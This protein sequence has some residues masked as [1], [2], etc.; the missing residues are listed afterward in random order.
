MDSKRSPI[1]A[2]RGL[3]MKVEDQE[4]VEVAMEEECSDDSGSVLPG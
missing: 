1:R 2:M 4:K 3:Q